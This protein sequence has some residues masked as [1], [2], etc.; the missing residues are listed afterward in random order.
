[1]NGSWAFCIVVGNWEVF[2]GFLRWVMGAKILRRMWKFTPLVSLSLI[3][4][5]CF[6]TLSPPL[7]GRVPTG[8]VKPTGWALG[9][10]RVQANGLAGHIRDFGA[11][12]KGSIWVEGGSIEYSAM[13]ESAPYWFNA[14]VAL[15]FQLDD[16][17]L[18]G[19]VRDFLDWTLDHQQSDGWIGPEPLIPNSTVPRLTWPRYLVLFGLIQYAEADPSQTDRIVNAIHRFIP[20]VHATWK[21]GKQGDR[22]LG[23]EF[24]YQFVRWE[25]MVYS[26]QWLYD[27]H[28]KGQEDLLLETMQLLRDAGFSWKNDWFQESIFPKEAATNLN[29]STHGVNTAEALKSEALAFR[30]TGDPTDRQNTFDRIDMLYRYHGR[31]SGTFAADEH[32]AGLNPSRGTELCDVVEQIFSFATIYGIFGNNSVADRAEKLA[33]NAL[34][35]GIMYDWWSHQYDQ[36]VNQI[37]TKVMDPPPWGDNGPNSNVFGFEPNYP[38]CTVNHPSGY[39]K[40][41]AH[42]FFTDKSDSSLLHVFLGPSQFKGTIDGNDV[43]VSVDTLYPFGTSLTYRITASKAFPFK[44]RV[45]GWAQTGKSMIAV[46]GGQAA[47]L[48][49][50][51]EHGLHTVQV[52]RGTSKVEVTLDAPTVIEPRFNGA[53]S[54]TRGAL[55]FALQLSNNETS[56]PG[57]R[58]AQALADVRRLYPNAPPEFLTPTDNHTTDHTLLPTSEWRLAIDPSTLKLVDKS[59]STTSLPEQVWA[60]GAQPLW[61]TG[62]SF[63]FVSTKWKV[64]G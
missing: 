1:M 52:P 5:H 56:A 44:I 45:P 3:L 38:C 48:Q 40:F 30:F 62:Q 34:P 12:V 63:S 6:G 43:T 41:W 54:V 64:F 25:E 2:R 39:P 16:V 18:K 58:S 61:F 60:P 27:N 13:H 11:Y 36:Q 31:A 9:Q 35:A 19:Q 37:W 24:D 21:A 42:S 17:R 51:N 7:F 22:S 10:A 46:N 59:A 33:Y 15:A 8:S 4:P 47:Q 26:L 23:G 57:L 29:M 53:V 32:V 20:L 28:P 14:Q 50:E 49:A 55:N